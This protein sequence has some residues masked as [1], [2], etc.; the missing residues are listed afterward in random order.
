MP[1]SLPGLRGGQIP[2]VRTAPTHPPTHTHVLHVCWTRQVSACRVTDFNGCSLSTLTK[3]T[4]TVDPT[5]AA[6]DELRAWFASHADPSS[7]TPVG[8]P[9]SGSAGGECVSSTT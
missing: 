4:V 7:F 5:G 9:G 8:Q 2:C 1:L 6:A 3:S